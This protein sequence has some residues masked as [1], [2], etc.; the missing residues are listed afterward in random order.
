MSCL[1]RSEN[2]LIQLV[3]IIT[4]KRGCLS[5][6]TF[7]RFLKQLYAWGREK[8]DGFDRSHFD[9]LS[10]D[11]RLEAARLLREALLRG[12]NTSAE[13]L[14]L[15]D[16]R[17]AKATLEEALQTMSGDAHVSLAVAKQLWHLTKESRYQEEM[18]AILQHPNDLLRRSAL[19]ALEDTP[20]DDRLMTVLQALV[21]DDPHEIIRSMAARHLI[22]GLGLITDIHDLDHPYIRIK[23][24]LSDNRKEVREKALAELKSQYWPQQSK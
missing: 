6:K 19:V 15:L 5:S 8:G 20:H 23:N 14:V 16:P 13:G 17:A 7:E 22:Y 18:I 1:G 4:R 21:K 11:E 10:P 12:D 3:S 2:K 24:E 9:G